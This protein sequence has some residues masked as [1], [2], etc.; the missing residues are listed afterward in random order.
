MVGDLSL[1]DIIALVIIGALAG[2]AAAQLLERGGRRKGASGWLRNTIIGIVGALVGSVLF[3]VL[4]MQLPEA[5]QGSISVA[6][7]I[8][9]F[10][11]ALLVIFVAGLI[12]R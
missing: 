2:S 6:D 4:D 10:V 9:A 5:L 1:G 3:R 7:V 8:V 11:G 12:N